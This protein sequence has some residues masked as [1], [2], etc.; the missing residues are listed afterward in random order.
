M[1][2]ILQLRLHPSHPSEGEGFHTENPVLLA[3]DWDLK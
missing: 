1:S 2:S 3:G